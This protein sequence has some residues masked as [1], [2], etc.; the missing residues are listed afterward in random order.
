MHVRVCG[1]GGGCMC[2]CVCWRGGGGGACACVCVCVCVCVYVC[3][4]LKGF[5][6][7]FEEKFVS[8]PA[9][10]NLRMYM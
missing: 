1:G 3:E 4:G 5:L 9:I 10:R 7:N 2:V 6:I 8:Q